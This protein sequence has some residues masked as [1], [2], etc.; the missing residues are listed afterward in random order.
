MVTVLRASGLRV[1]IYLDDHRPPHVHVFGDG[2]AKIDLRGANGKPVLVWAIRMSRSELKRA[3]QLV[4]D[5]Q[6]ALLARWEE[7]HGGT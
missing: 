2:E 4:T 6:G 3:V 1:A 5:Q 7:I